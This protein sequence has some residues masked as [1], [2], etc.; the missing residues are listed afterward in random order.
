VVL[1]DPA[2]MKAAAGIVHPPPAIQSGE[3]FNRPTDVCVHPATGE[4]FVTDGYGNSR[5]HRLQADGSHIQSWGVA[6]T[7][8][9]QFNLPHSVTLHPDQDKVLL[10]CPFT[11][12]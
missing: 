10:T 12:V 6:G 9:G 2:E 5:V 1:T 8:E 3:R 4:I 7:D 11:S